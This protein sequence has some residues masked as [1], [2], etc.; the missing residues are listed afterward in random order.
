MHHRIRTRLPRG[1]AALVR[2][3]RRSEARPLVDLSDF[4]PAKLSDFGPAL[5]TEWILESWANSGLGFAG[6]CTGGRI[7]AGAANEAV[8]GREEARRPP[9]DPHVRCHRDARAR[10]TRSG[11]SRFHKKLLD[12]FYWPVATDPH[13]HAHTARRPPRCAWSGASGQD[14]DERRPR[15]R[16]CRRRVLSVQE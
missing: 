2:R 15:T 9:I 4:Q 5:T 10:A 3:A 1:A 11:P 7:G 6:Q 16:R 12:T 14:Q 8:L 13:R